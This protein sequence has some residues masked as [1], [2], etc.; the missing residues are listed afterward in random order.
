MNFEGGR[1]DERKRQD[2]GGYNGENVK[3]EKYEDSEV[4]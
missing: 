3:S 1:M 4:L 2:A